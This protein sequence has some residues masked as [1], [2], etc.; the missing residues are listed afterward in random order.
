V[1]DAAHRPPRRAPG[2]E[3]LAH[4]VQHLRYELR[5][6]GRRFGELLDEQA[7]RFHAFTAADTTRYRALGRAGAAEPILRLEI[8]R[9]GASCDA[10]DDAAIRRAVAAVRQEALES[11]PSPRQQ[12]VPRL[13]PA[14]HPY[15]NQGDDGLAAIDRRDVCAF[16]AENYVPARGAFAIAGRLTDAD[17]VRFDALLGALPRISGAERRPLPPAAWAPAR[18]TIDS[19]V[20]RPVFLAAWRRRRSTRRSSS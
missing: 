10:I 19:P 12:I 17:M 1:P 9:L 14:G 11:D 16:L 13:Y 8:A 5:V 18:V 2:K 15:G 7:L 6:D 20:R 3:G 4:L